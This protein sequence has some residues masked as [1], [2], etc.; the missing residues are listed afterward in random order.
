M[1]ISGMV[2]PARSTL[3]WF[4][5]TYILDI[6][7]YAPELSKLKYQQI[8]DVIADAQTGGK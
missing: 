1:E 7:H 4:C 6:V 8:I 3:V 2:I 5:P